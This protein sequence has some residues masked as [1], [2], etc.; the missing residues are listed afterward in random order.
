MNRRF[1]LQ[2]GSS[3]K[4]WQ[5]RQKGKQF[6][7]TYGRIGGKGRSTT[8]A[9]DTPAEA[10]KAA[11]KS[12]RQKMEMGYQETASSVESNEP[13]VWGTQLSTL[14]KRLKSK[15]AEQR[16]EAARGVS[17]IGPR[18]AAAVSVLVKAL[19]D[20]SDL[21]RHWAAAALGYIGPAARSAAKDLSR[22]LKDSNHWTRVAAAKALYKVGD[23]AKGL[24]AIVACL[25]DPSTREI[26]GNTIVTLG[27]G[28]NESFVPILRGRLKSKDKQDVAIAAQTLSQIVQFN[29]LMAQ[30]DKQKGGDKPPS[31]PSKSTTKEPPS[32]PQLAKLL[33]PWFEKHKKPAWKPK[34]RKGDG[35]LTDSKFCGTP[36]LSPKEAWPA[37][38]ICDRPLELFLQLNLQHLPTPIAK[39]FGHGLLQLFYCRH[40]CGDG[41]SEY[42]SDCMSHIRAANP[43]GP[44][45][46]LPKRREAGSYPARRIV[47]WQKL[48]DFP[49]SGDQ[50][51]LGLRREHD[52]ESNTIR[53]SCNQLNLAITNLPA[54][55]RYEYD[56][57]FNC[58]IPL[59]DKLGGWPC[60][61]QSPNYP[62]CPRCDSRMQF[63]FQVDSEHNVPFM[64]G[65]SGCGYV[66]QCK[67]H[68]GVVAFGWDC[69]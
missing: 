6:T 58:G 45:R 43:N 64:F 23:R 9:F 25:D 66:F 5:I 10:K 19:S 14:I 60:W 47:G 18:A 39:T 44:G 50:A 17:D 31:A 51:E 36:W 62:Y 32:P 30:R 8:K 29:K 27:P 28:L 24:T 40:N 34:V 1:E 48:D 21:M 69:H 46:R 2:H 35:A 68:K 26:I 38:Q 3:S 22:A 55:K 53:V 13:H 4:F 63:V 61:I 65:D 15:D 42:F 57:V 67:K 41:G 56:E 11:E 49:D 16:V 7:T 54:S 12:V 20:E 59:G 37:C 33:Q 52:V